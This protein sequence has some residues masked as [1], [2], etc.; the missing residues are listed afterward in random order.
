MTEAQQNQ[1]PI[2]LKGID[3]V[4][5]S[6]KANEQL[7]TLFEHF[8]FTTIAQD[9]TNKHMAQNDVHFLLSTTDAGFSHDFYQAHGPSICAMGWLVED[10]QAA[11]KT[12]VARGAKA[13]EPKAGDLTLDM[14]AI[15]GIGD[16]LIYFVERPGSFAQG[17]E[18]TGQEKGFGKGFLLIDHL[19]NNVD[20]GRL[21]HWANFYKDIF[22]FTEVRRFDIRGQET[23]L[24]SYA[25]RSPDGSFCIPINEG[26]EYKSQINEYLREYRGEGVQHLAL[27]TPELLSS[28][29]LM[30]ET[31]VAFLDI[32][33]AYYEEAF[34]RVPNVTEDRD[35]IK[36]HQVLIDGDPEGYLLQIFTQNI[37]GPIF[38]ELIQR[39][40]HLS[41]GEG[42]FGALF[43]SIERDQKRRGAI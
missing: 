1:N 19:T 9:A 39:K 26:T 30:E 5:F 32:D 28:L 11:L 41:F 43:R 33:D 15:V 14:P 29:D 31:G 20:Q 4:Q 22:G 36:R 37:I 3:F 34:A 16:S 25:L 38:F 18:K 35:H 8:G 24:L 13:Y 23:G 10:A 7:D 42:N 40:N 2:G 21:V 12:A 27:L 17:L 6:A